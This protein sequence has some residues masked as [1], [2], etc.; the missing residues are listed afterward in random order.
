MRLLSHSFIEIKSSFAVISQLLRDRFRRF[1]EGEIG[2]ETTHWLEMQGIPALLRPLVL[3]SLFFAFGEV[4]STKTSYQTAGCPK[5][6]I[7]TRGPLPKSIKP[8]GIVIF[9]VDISQKQ[10]K[11]AKSVV[12]KLTL[13]DNLRFLKAHVSGASTHSALTPIIVDRNLYWTGLDI[14]KGLPAKLQIK[15]RA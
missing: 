12:Y 8:G 11:R 1:Q 6:V 10:V 13:P 9:T 4:S 5:L 3:F 2:G 14:K 15:V 7:R